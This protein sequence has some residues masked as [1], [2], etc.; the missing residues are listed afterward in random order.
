M[1]PAAT[2]ATKNPPRNEKA[3]DSEVVAHSAI[4]PARPVIAKTDA[5]RV[6]PAR[7]LPSRHKVSPMAMA[8]PTKMA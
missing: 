2:L 8:A 1:A 4:V 6:N 7:P 5:K 3:V